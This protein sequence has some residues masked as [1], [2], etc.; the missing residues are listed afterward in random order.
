LLD[1][2]GEGNIILG[3]VIGEC[4]SVQASNIP[5]KIYP[6][7]KTMCG[8]QISHL[9]AQLSFPRSDEIKHF[10]KDT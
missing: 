10:L 4:L 1:P 3:N 8:R 7:N 6:S 5:K 2:E 9:E